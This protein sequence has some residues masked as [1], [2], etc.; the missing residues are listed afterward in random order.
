MKVNPL[1]NVKTGISKY[2]KFLEKFI[3]FYKI[4]M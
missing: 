3:R 1:C 4:L 2:P